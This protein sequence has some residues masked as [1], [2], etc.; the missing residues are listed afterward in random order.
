MKDML[1]LSSEEV[2]VSKES[3]FWAY[4]KDMSYCNWNIALFVDGSRLSIKEMAMTEERV[5]SPFE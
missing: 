2:G 1:D 4:L 5:S 3:T